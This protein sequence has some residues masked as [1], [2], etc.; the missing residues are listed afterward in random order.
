[1]D[2]MEIMHSMDSADSMDSNGQYRH[3]KIYEQ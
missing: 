3:N 2:S 1:M